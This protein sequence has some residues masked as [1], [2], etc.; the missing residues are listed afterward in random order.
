MPT[1]T[2]VKMNPFIVFG[3]KYFQMIEPD[4]SRVIEKN[5]YTSSCEFILRE[6]S[7]GTAAEAAAARAVARTAVAGTEGAG[8]AIEGG[9]A[10]GASPGKAAEAAGAAARAAVEVADRVF[11][12]LP[13]K[14]AAAGVAAGATGARHLFCV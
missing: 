10:A 1:S 5:M 4:E 13:A 2:T 12:W 6:A 14:T 7:S 11:A 9:A 3:V 8:A